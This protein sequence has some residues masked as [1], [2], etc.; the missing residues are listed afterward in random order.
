M[1]SYTL[2]THA[3]IWYIGGFSTIS[4]KSKKIIQEIFE[5]KV[6]CYISTMVILEAFYVSL[7][8]SDFIFSNFLK[9]ID[10]SNI[11]I[12]SFDK[13]VLNQSVE[14]PEKMDIHDRIIVATAIVT[15]TPLVTK[16]KILREKFPNETIW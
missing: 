5:G 9:I 4:L 12:V 10:K 2:D 7:K 16:D 14:L 13:K 3:L 1:D 8:H 11:K 6:N 15:N